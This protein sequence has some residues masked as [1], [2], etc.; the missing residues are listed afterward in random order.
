MIP[1]AMPIPARATC[2]LGASGHL[3]DAVV[4]ALLAAGR[5]VW[6]T[7]C[8]GSA[9][10]GLPTLQVDLRDEGAADVIAAHS[11]AAVVHC[12]APRWPCADDDPWAVGPR[13]A[14]RLV[15]ALLPAWT[16]AGGGALVLV[17]GLAVSHGVDVPWP[18]AA[19]H[20]AL[21]ALARTLSHQH[22]R[23]GVQVSVLAV[24][25]LSGGAASALPGAAARRA[26]VERHAGTGRRPTAAQAAAMVAWL[27]RHPSTTGS[28]VALHGAL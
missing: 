4:A 6:G 27:V 1:A 23:A 21:P 20:G 28:V 18:V 3:G 8:T 22:G 12:A 19:A 26:S 10:P 9:R 25:D 24:S 2:V 7:T 11:P 15:E 13:A 5:P 14:A 17:A 16:A